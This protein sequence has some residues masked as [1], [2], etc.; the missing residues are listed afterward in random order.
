M[1]ISELSEQQKSV[2]LARAMGWEYGIVGDDV[3]HGIATMRDSKGDMIWLE[4]FEYPAAYPY[5]NL[6]DPANMALA[7][8]VLNW[9]WNQ[10][11]QHDNDP[12]DERQSQE[13]ILKI[14]QVLCDYWCDDPAKAQAVWL[15][16]VLELA[17]KAGLVPAEEE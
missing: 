1:D 15:D 11:G 10:T 4:D 5:K 3:G 2:M 16:L 7:W 17:I 14:D 8:G 9:A 12:L 13:W 6:Y